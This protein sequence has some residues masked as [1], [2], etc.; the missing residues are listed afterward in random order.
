VGREGVFVGNPERKM[1]L[2]R[3][4][5]RGWIILTLILQKQEAVMWSRLTWLRVEINGGLL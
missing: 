5:L 3:P 4:R 2:G 1:F